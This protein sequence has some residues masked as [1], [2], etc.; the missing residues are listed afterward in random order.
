M[1]AD[2][3]ITETD[4]H[5]YVDGR[6]G[7]ER[8]G[9]V[10]E[11]LAAHPDVAAQVMADMAA[12]RALRSV[13]DAPLPE[14]RQRTRD[15]AVALGL[16]LAGR[17]GPGLRRAAAA[18]SL[19]LVFAGGWFAGQVATSTPLTPDF[20]DDAMMSRETSLLRARMASQPETV[21]LDRAEISAATQVV[22]PKLPRSWR[23]TDVQV[24]PSE[25]GPSVGMAFQS[26]EL[27]PIS[28]FAVRTRDSSRIEP[29]TIRRDG[30]VVAYW[31]NGD[32]AYA[33]MA[34]RGYERV[35]Q[36]ARRL[37]ASVAADDGRS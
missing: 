18:A 31:R 32:M 23:M 9:E 4:L 3:P 28:L 5:A 25:D 22:L 11:Y 10:E 37:A 16:A 30:G 27:G 15:Q 8:C 17:R 19:A 7:A 21:R 6:L 1:A 14:G 2:D 34:S 35:S 24:Y 29:T 33:L 13:L 36:T 26:R 20:V 12:T